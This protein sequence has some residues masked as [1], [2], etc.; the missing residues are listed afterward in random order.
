MVIDGRTLPEAEQLEA[1]VC[2]VGAGPA[3]ITLTL[4]LARAGY[5]VCVLESGGR[6]PEA[7]K[8][9][10]TDG[11]SVGY[12][13]YPLRATRIRAFGGTS[14]G[15]ASTAAETAEGW[16]SSPFDAIDFERRAEIPHSGWPFGYADLRPFYERAQKLCRLG[17]YD[18]AP[19]SWE[20]ADAKAL[21]LD[22]DI[23]TI[24]F[25]H[26]FES[27]ASYF[28]EVAGNDRVQLV[29]NA[30][31]TEIETDGPAGEVTRVLVASDRPARFSV[32]ARL[33]VLAAGGIENA[34]LLLLSRRSQPAGLGNG[35]GLVGRFF[36]E[37][38]TCRSGYISPAR[39]DFFDRIP[40]YHHH[41]D[42]DATLQAALSA[43]EDV[44]RR[45]GLL[46]C[47]LILVPASRASLS[48]GLRA[49]A[50]L[51]RALGR[52]PLPQGLSR[53]LATAALK[54]PEIARAGLRGR[55]K[56]PEIGR[57]EYAGRDGLQPDV[58]ALRVQAEQAPNPDS[59][60]LLDDKRDRVRAAAGAP[61]LA[62][63]RA[64]P[65][66]GPPDAGAPR[67]RAPRPRPRAR[68]AEARRR[69]P[70]DALPRH[71][72]PHGDDTHARGR[73]PGRRR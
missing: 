61:G 42:G 7:E 53:H 51:Y 50:T 29:L 46:N 63:D 72:S 62:A 21:D 11:K 36:Q 9:K 22:G 2:V 45:E 55:H 59:R 43:S 20:T 33:Y 25:H 40:L 10:L 47:A 64:R 4:E 5:R 56:L 6:E 1:D 68:R 57:P 71:V 28:D 70:R 34:R 24:V 16:R 73:K 58:V 31:V 17:R 66:V 3:G 19:S 8:Q 60:V 30:T 65:A 54:L 49:A 13:Y 69:G 48:D 32:N 23:R 44:M 15:W 38:L 41:Q 14:T 39:D 18:H 52:R 35:N 37:H 27:F 12:W 26:G 67:S